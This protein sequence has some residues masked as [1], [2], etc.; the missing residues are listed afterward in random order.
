MK[1][2][3][4]FLKRI[5]NAGADFEIDPFESDY[6]RLTNTMQLILVGLTLIIVPF[7]ISALPE[8]R[9]L[10]ILLIVF[11]VLWLGTG[12][13]NKYGHH[14]A[15]K[16]Y[17][18]VVTLAFITLGSLLVG[19][20]SHNHLG[21]LSIIIISF[22]IYSEKE[23]IWIILTNVVAIGLFVLL[24]LWFVDHKGLLTISPGFTVLVRLVTISYLF[25]NVLVSSLYNRNTIKKTEDQLAVAKLKSDQLLLNVL[26][27]EIAEQLKTTTHSIANQFDDATILFAD[28]VGFT[29]YAQTVSPQELVELLDEIFSAFDQEAMQYGLEKIKTIGDAYMIAAGLPI[30]RSDHCEI[31]AELALSMKRLIT[32]K[33]TGKSHALNLRI[34]FHSGPVV[35]GVIGKNKF[36]YDLWGESV[37][38]A[39]E[40]EHICI[41]GEILVSSSA[42]DRLKS[43]FQ[44]IPGPTIM[45]GNQEEAKT[46]VLNS[47]IN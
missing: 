16:L 21:L 17:L 14:L 39:H 15:A 22:F 43:K 29:A 7:A 30:P 19:R 33:F 46:Y 13:L 37:D 12:V 36:C 9:Y 10:V 45:D 26:P 40:M 31:V 27:V 18:T 34:G 23:R 3:Q 32:D 47:K 42:F 5:I 8:L 38:M 25:T 41:P 6:I 44:F 28:I 4:F 11:G 35:A 1:L 2:A 24:E 20:E